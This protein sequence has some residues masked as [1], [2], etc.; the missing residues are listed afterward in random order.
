MRSIFIAF[1]VCAV[2]TAC[3]S[4]TGSTGLPP[5]PDSSASATPGPA[6]QAPPPPN[7]ISV[8]PP[9]TQTR[10][11]TRVTANPGPITASNPSTA[12]VDVNRSTTAA[13]GANSPAPSSFENSCAPPPYLFQS[14]AG[15]E[16]VRVKDCKNDQLVYLP[17]SAQAQ[18][19]IYV[20]DCQRR[21]GAR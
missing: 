10:S 20:S 5:L 16:A 13:L 21:C 15:Y 6:G 9:G 11:P 1:S 2:L 8:P 14:K 3:T 12:I 7:A 19:D 18:I 4:S 17:S